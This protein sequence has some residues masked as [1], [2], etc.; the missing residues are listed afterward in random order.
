MPLV[1]SRTS[2]MTRVVTA[3]NDVGPLQKSVDMYRNYAQILLATSIGMAMRN[4][5]LNKSS[6]SAIKI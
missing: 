4:P 2:G 3:M 6:Y 5:A 1:I